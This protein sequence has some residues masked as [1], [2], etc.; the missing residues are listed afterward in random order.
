VVSTLDSTLTPAALRTEAAYLRD[1][2]SFERPYGWAWA[3]A[4]AAACATSPH[5]AAPRWTDALAPLAA[6]VADIA[7]ALGRI[8]RMPAAE[9]ARM[10]DAA[11]ERWRATASAEVNFSA[12]ASALRS[13]V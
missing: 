10:R 5:P 1:N 12:F 3:L 4:L 6:T 9:R 8:M 11:V 13:L 7:L 2:P